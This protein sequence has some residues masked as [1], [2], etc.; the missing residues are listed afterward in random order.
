MISWIQGRYTALHQVFGKWECPLAFEV[1]R[2]VFGVEP[3]AAALHWVMRDPN[4]RCLRRAKLQT[5]N[6][7]TA[8]NRRRFL[9]SEQPPIFRKLDAR[10]YIIEA[11]GAKASFG[12]GSNF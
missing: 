9:I 11:C 7:D 1:W 8:E 2:L 3:R 12:D 5:P 10:Q 4:R 6:W